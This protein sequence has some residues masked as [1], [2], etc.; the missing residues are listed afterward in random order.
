MPQFHGIIAPHPLSILPHEANST[1][2]GE[3]E[4]LIKNYLK[5][6][7]KVGEWQPDTIIIISPRGTCYLEGITI[8]NPT[9][10]QF[11]AKLAEIKQSDLTFES[12]KNLIHSLLK[13]CQE[14][15]L[16]VI[17]TDNETLDPGAIVPLFYQT[18][19]LK[20]TPDL[21]YLNMGHIRPEKHFQFGQILNQ[22]AH[23]S[24]KKVL[25]IAAADLSHKLTKA[26]PGG[27][28]KLGKAFD[29]EIREDLNQ[30]N[31]ERITLYDSFDMDEAGEAGVRPIC[32]MLGF[33]QNQ[34][35]HLQEH[36][37]SAPEGVGYLLSSTFTLR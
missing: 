30:Q 21:V 20:K 9:T 29:K 33:L 18:K 26:S 32:A 27:Y 8:H 3:Y 16:T 31:Y 36:N 15:G 11:I 7:K 6:T 13:H 34:P 25:F 14:N 2:I 4:D 24:N 23:T 35:H 28:S 10:N 12:D 5:L 19:G 37:Y 22:L 17:E 1:I